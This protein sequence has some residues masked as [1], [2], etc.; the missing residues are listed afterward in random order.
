[1]EEGK[2][3]FWTIVIGIAFLVIYKI[4]FVVYAGNPSVTMLKNIR[5]GV[6]TVTSGYYTEKR[7]SGN[8]F[9]FISNKGNFIES[10]EDGEF[11]N[12]RRYLVAFDSLDIRDGVL[13]LDKF[14][15]T[16]S[17]RKYHIYPEYGMYEASWSLPNIPFQYDK[18]DI[19][20]EVRMNVKSD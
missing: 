5:Y 7:R 8:D 2:T 19:E 1:M 10:N 13:L 14:D 11:I 16:D 18:S 12:G 3:V 15:I 9:K 20:Y 6:G 4:I 17:L